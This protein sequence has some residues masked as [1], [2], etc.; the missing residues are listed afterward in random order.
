MKEIN[1]SELKQLIDE[2]ADIQL[3]DVRE[4]NEVAAG[5]MGGEHI[6]MGTIPNNVDK[7]DKNKQVIVHC[8]S[9]K[10]SA[11]VIQYLENNHGYTNLYNL[12]GGILAWRDEIDPSLSV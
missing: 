1:V 11:N 10:R 5:S 2:G 9:G 4:D 6:A 12:T 3:I 8:R 7:I